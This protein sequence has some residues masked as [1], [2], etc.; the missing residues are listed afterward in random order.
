L[1]P[2]TEVGGALGANVGAAVA[3]V[4]FGASVVAVR[5]AVRDVPPVSLAVLRFGIG[6]VLLLLV[7]LA[8][9]RDS[10]RLAREI[11]P[12]FALLALVF[13]TLFPLSFNVGLQFT[14]A[15]RGALMLA[16]MPVWSAVMARKAV[17]ERLRPLQT[18]GVALSIAGIGVAFAERGLF[19]STGGRAILGDALLLLTAFWGALYGVLSKRALA[20]HPPLTVTTYP[21]LIGTAYLLPVALVEGLPSAVT[22]LDGTTLW[23]VLFVAVLG[24]AVAFY[25]WTAALS[26]LTPTQVA[27]YVNINPLVA[28]SLAALL[29]H[30]RLSILFVVG[31]AAVVGG[32]LLVNSPGIRRRSYGPGAGS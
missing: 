11:V 29:L 12:R 9:R 21:M 25:L 24:G 19:A 30:E 1:Q 15:S 14:E 13:Y 16:T 18:G 17:G 23:L 8:V 2:K 32:V 5:V 31:F 3:A 6:G 27:V 22:N 20:R 26:R 28:A 7:A 10:L 4:F